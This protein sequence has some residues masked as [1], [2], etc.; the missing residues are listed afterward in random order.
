MKNRQ[1]KAIGKQIFSFLQ[2]VYDFYPIPLVNIGCLGQSGHVL[3]KK[4]KFC[5]VGTY[6]FLNLS[7]AFNKN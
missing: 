1:K 6:L 2:E 5:G 4:R 3:Q 7:V